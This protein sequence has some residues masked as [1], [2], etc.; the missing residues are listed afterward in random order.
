MWARIIEIW[1]CGV[2]VTDQHYSNLYDAMKLLAFGSFFWFVS[3]QAI[4]ISWLENEEK[5]R[6]EYFECCECG[7][8]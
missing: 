3:I 1:V 7:N 2:Y 4:A 8:K 6:N 5:D